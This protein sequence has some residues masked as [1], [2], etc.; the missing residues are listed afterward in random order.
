MGDGIDSPELERAT[1]LELALDRATEQ[2]M[3]S[4]QERR[5]GRRSAA[6]ASTSTAMVVANDEVLPARLSW[7]GIEVTEEFQEYAMRVSRG[8]QLE[9]FRGQV[10]ARPCPEFPWSEPANEQEHTSTE[11]LPRFRS[12]GPRVAAW[13]FGI[14]AVVMAGLGIGSGTAN[15]G[16]QQDPFVLPPTTTSLALRPTARELD[17]PSSL[18]EPETRIAS[19]IE[20]ALAHAVPAETH[21]ARALPGP[22]LGSSLVPPRLPAA[23]APPAL[24]RANTGLSSGA[25]NPSSS[26]GA[27]NSS[28]FGA[29]S[30]GPSAPSSSVTASAT[31]G[32]RTPLASAPGMSMS[33]SLASSATSGA[34]VPS[35]SSHASTTLFSDSPSF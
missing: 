5:G 14:G 22:G 25:L 32:P 28:S 15:S 19:A 12:R 29:S 13:L 18:T 8:E 3:A 9:P 2:Y 10:L 20:S 33:A 1:P 7:R 24:P 31:S 35:A 23:S 30:I 4:M 27:S 34:P 11:E 6:R 21:A 17:A 26:S 16:D